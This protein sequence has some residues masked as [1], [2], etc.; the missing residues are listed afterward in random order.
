MEQQTE[1]NEAKAD[2]TYMLV[3][4]AYGIAGVIA[5]LKSLLK[6]EQHMMGRDERK[7][8]ESLIDEIMEA[9]QNG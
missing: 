5:G 2:E 6:N 1:A 4:T 3:L 8:I 7:F 9:Y